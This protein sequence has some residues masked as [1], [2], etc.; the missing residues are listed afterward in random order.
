MPTAAQLGPRAQ[1]NRTTEERHDR[2]SGYYSQNREA[3]GPAGN[4]QCPESPTIPRTQVAPGCMKAPLA[5]GAASSAP[6]PLASSMG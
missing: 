4:A 1:Q 3:F 5:R 6:P 2:C